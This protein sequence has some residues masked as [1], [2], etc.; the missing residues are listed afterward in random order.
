[1]RTRWVVRILLLMLILGAHF[2]LGAR[3]SAA[4]QPKPCANGDTACCIDPCNDFCMPGFAIEA[5]C[6]GRM[7]HC[8][9]FDDVFWTPVDPYLPDECLPDGR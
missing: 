6:D 7:C 9:C 8:L 4:M 3:V 5:Y 1:M 2:G